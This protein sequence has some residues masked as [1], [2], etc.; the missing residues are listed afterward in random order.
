[1]PAH[2]SPLSAFQAADILHSLAASIVEA[3]LE[4]FYATYPDTRQKHGPKGIA[5]CREDCLAHIEFL[6]AALRTDTLPTFAQYVLWVR[7]LLVS[8]GRSDEG[9][10]E[11]LEIMRLQ[12]LDQAGEAVYAVAAPPL[13]QVAAALRDPLA[14]HTLY[15]TPPAHV[16]M[17]GYL[18]AVLAGHYRLAQQMILDAYAGGM[19]VA[20]L[21]LQVFEPALYE[22]GRLWETG[23]ASVAQEHL[24]T[25]TTQLLL[26]I[27]YS[28]VEL[29]AAPGQR[30]LVACLSGNTHQ[31]GARMVSDILQMNGYDTF[32]LGADTPERDLMSMIQE[33][34]PQVIGLSATLARHIE[35][36]QQAIEHIRSDFAHYHPV[37]MVGGIA[38]NRV[39][40]LWERVG[41]DVWG[42]NA[43]QAIERLMSG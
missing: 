25:S 33:V 8:R 38:F 4:H 18:K 34:Q 21:Y 2:D 30:A 22:V 36:V 23:Q 26:N 14:S 12:I 17:Q 43:G 11:M 41:A 3:S 19:P 32:F 5:K 6:V 31:V 27:L 37:I 10:I 20:D 13:E 7:G 15:A 24:V 35:P 39:E 9:L 28:R 40:G 1:M 29:P 42:T 16:L